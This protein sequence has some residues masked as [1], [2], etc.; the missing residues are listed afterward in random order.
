MNKPKPG[1]TESQNNEPE[2]N[3]SLKDELENKH[4]EEQSTNE[5][6]M[7]EPAMN[8]QWDNLLDDWQSQPYEKVDIAKLLAQLK[9]RTLCA[10]AILA[11]DAIATLGIFIGAVWFYMNKPEEN[12]LF[13][14]LSICGVG[15]LIYTVLEF[16]IRIDTWNMD[17]SDS[18]QVFEKSI[19]AAKG[20]LQIAK[21][22]KLSCYFFFPLL[23]WFVWEMS[24]V[25]DKSVLDAFIFSNVF[26]L[27]FYGFS[28]RYQKKRELEYKQLNE[29]KNE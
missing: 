27:V 5:S 19:S 9:R 10:K 23:N 20:A 2:S 1:S 8:E 12:I 6:A 13:I 17:A 22:L 29:I 16:K 14:Y 7:N 18:K 25:K 21:L 28:H 24:K 11:F 26:I 15:S 4:P 3:G